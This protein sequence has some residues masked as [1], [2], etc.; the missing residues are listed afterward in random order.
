MVRQW[1]EFYYQDR[2]AESYME[3]LPDFV[4]LAEAYGHIGIRIEKPS[5]VEDAL[6]EAIKL[7][8][9]LVFLDF[10]TDRKQN[11]YPM[12]G[13]GK[14]LDEMV[15]PPHMCETKSDTHVNNV[16]ARSYDKRSMP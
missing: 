13:N 11:V 7:K 10:I 9:R 6:K 5:E 4:K 12:V 3:S 16:K 1:Q 14:G 15:L 2:Y 8:N